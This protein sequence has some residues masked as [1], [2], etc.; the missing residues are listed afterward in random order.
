GHL[1]AMMRSV[2]DH[3][4]HDL[5]C[6]TDIGI[7]LHIAIGDLLAYSLIRQGRR[8]LL[9]LAI[10]QGPVG[11]QNMQIVVCVGKK[12]G[13]SLAQNTR[14]PDGVGAEDMDQ[15]P[16]YAAIGGLEI[17]D[18]L[19]VG[20][21]LHSVNQSLAGPRRVAEVVSKHAGGNRHASSLL[22]LGSIRAALYS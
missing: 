2:I 9:P 8:P 20:K 16:Q 17:V 5:P 12:T 3:V 11:L 19:F 13:P 18:Q 1:P 22:L 7:A 10:E 21:M 4:E 14:E 15:C 6:R